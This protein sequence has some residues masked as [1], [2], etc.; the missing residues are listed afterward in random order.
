MFFIISWRCVVKVVADIKTMRTIVTTLVLSEFAPRK[1]SESWAPKMVA[2]SAWLATALV[3]G[4]IGS[5]APVAIFSRPLST[6]K[7]PKKKGDWTRIGRHEENGLVPSL[8]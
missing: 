4:P 1:W 3:M 5:L 8:R 7:R 2:D 6:R